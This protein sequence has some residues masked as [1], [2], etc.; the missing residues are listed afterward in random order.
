ME[1]MNKYLIMRD[2]LQT[3][4]YTLEQ[5]R[6][7]RLKSTDLVWL[8]G[9]STNWMLA[10]EIEELKDLV[11]GGLA[12]SEI[13]HKLSASLNADHLEKSTKTRWYK[14]ALSASVLAILILGGVLVKKSFEP[15]AVEIKGVSINP[16]GSEAVT[17]S[18]N[19]QNALSKEFIPVEAKP[20]KVKPKELKK[21]VSAQVNNY[22]VKILGGIKDLEITV[23]NFSDHLLD[24]V[25]LKVDYLKPKGEII[26]SEMITI[27]DIKA[28]EA[29]TIEVPPSS[30]GVKVNYAITDIVSKEY[31]SILEEL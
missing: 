23:Q 25:T 9:Y 11:D 19:F 14:I 29:K 1:R 4:P 26:N 10:G 7:D 20:K 22:E 31:K 30:R 27:K 5:L 8:Q 3:G 12:K 16:H 21:M 18:E 24:E 2:N 13:P 15:E 17:N 6:L 28:G